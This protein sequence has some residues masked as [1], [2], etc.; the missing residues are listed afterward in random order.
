MYSLTLYQFYVLYDQA[1]LFWMWFTDP[2]EKFIFFF[3]AEIKERVM[4][5]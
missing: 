3:P 1:E 5:F 2:D 4:S